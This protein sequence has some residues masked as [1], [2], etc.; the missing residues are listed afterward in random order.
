MSATDR[1]FRV[2]DAAT[3]RDV[4]RDWRDYVFQFQT[5]W[6][7]LAEACRNRGLEPSSKADYVARRIAELCRL[8]RWE[9]FDAET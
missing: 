8:N 3:G 7:S 1:R 9:S 4:G 5:E 6:G 2:R